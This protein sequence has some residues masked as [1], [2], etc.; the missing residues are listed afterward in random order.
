VLKWR[1]VRKI[2]LANYWQKSA[3][4][5]FFIPTCQLLVA[6]TVFL[7]NTGTITGSFLCRYWLNFLIPECQLLGQFQP[8]IMHYCSSSNGIQQWPKPKTKRKIIILFIQ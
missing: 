3:I 8:A 4:N 2:L 1:A 5:G 7:A 6:F